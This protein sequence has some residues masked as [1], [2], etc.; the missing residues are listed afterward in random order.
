MLVEQAERTMDLLP[1]GSDDV[2]HKHMLRDRSDILRRTSG[3]RKKR[4]ADFSHLLLLL[5]AYI[6]V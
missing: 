2:I 4:R 6:F 1:F 5:L 3:G